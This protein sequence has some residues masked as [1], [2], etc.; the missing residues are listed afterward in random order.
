MK[1]HRHFFV[2]KY[3]TF[4]KLERETVYKE[5]SCGKGKKVIKYQPLEKLT[6]L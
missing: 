4:E 2:L 1:K 3:Q 5:C 6:P